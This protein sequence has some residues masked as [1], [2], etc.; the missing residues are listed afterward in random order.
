MKHYSESRTV[1]LSAVMMAAI[2][3]FFANAEL[4]QTYL[5]AWAYMLVLMAREA[6]GVYLRF[7]TTT[8]I[9]TRK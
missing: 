2:S 8:A 3:A 9:T 7:T 1:L 6:Y 5:P 4:T